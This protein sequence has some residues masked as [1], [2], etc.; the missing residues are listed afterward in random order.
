MWIYKISLVYCIRLLNFKFIEFVY[1]GLGVNEFKSVML[2]IK[3]PIYFHYYM[4]AR[5]KRKG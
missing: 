5:F 2:K 1:W 4:Q 3:R